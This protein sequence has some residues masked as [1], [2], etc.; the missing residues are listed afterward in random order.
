MESGRELERIVS[1]WIA[2]RDS[3]N[4][5][6]ADEA[7]LQRWLD[8]SDLRQITWLRLHRI[9]KETGRLNALG[10]GVEPGRIPE[11]GQWVL[12]PFYDSPPAN[13]ESLHRPKRRTL[14]AVAASVLLASALFVFKGVPLHGHRYS[15]PVGGMSSLPLPDGSKITLNTGSRIR[16]DLADA[17]RRAV[18]EQGEAFFD[19]ARDANRPFVVTAGDQRILVLGTKFSVRREGDDIRVA[20]TEGAVQVGDERLVAGTVVRTGKAGVL[21]LKKALN[22]VEEELSWRSGVIVF[23][24]DTLADA[25]AEFNRYTER[26]IEIVDPR[27]AE[28]RVAGSFQSSNAE[29][30]VRLLEQGYSL[31][32]EYGSDRILLHAR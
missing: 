6:E 14:W 21:V 4:W 8:E 10:A 1:E 30:F 5:R 20:V 27:V 16:I 24:D 18:L 17:E 22:E 2:R 9:W 31:R 26:K 32:V 25:I 3:G 7:E 11:P 23:R 13:S 29:D 28:M 15:T 12:S 19:V